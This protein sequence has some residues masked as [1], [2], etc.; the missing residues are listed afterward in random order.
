MQ[1]TLRPATAG[2]YAW[3][4]E[5]KRLTMRAYVE[6]TWG[7]WDEAAQEAFFRRSYRSDTVQLVLVNG[8]NAGLLHVERER[9]DLF[10]ANIQIHPTFQN[11]GLGS[12]VI[13]TVLESA[14]ALQLPVR[15]Q[16]LQVNHAAQQLY[17]RLGFV[18]A[19]QTPT[20]V[21]MRWMPPVA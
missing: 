16:V 4:W 19:T 5:L 17:L 21:V 10:L 12:A 8:Q 11:R 9:S 13:R 2:D 20:H 18:V 1:F 7:L 3:L 15:L 14:Q 6:Q